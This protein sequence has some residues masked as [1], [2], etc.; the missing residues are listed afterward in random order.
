MD[1]LLPL[2]KS[3]NRSEV[4]TLKNLLAINSSGVE[5]DKRADLFERIQ[6]SRNHDEQVVARLL[7]YSGSSEKAYI[8]LKSRLRDDILNLLML[9]ED[10]RAFETAFAQAAFECRRW[11]IQGE[12]LLA[13]GVYDGAID[14]LEKA[15]HQAH[16]YEL[17]AEFILIADLLRNHSAVKGDLDTFKGINE[18]I[19]EGQGDLN[20]V[21]KAKQ[22][23]YEI[24]VPGL[25]HVN[26]QRGYKVQAGELLSKLEN[27][28]RRTSSSR[29]AFYQHLAALN[30]YSAL[31]EFPE[32]LRHGRKLL[33]QVSE[34]QLLKSDANQAGVNMEMAGICLNTGD[35]ACAVRHAETAVGLFK[36]GMVN[37]MQALMIL[38]FAYFRSGN[39]SEATR[40]LDLAQSHKQALVDPLLEH[41][42]HL[43]RSG[44]LFSQ[45]DYTQSGKLLKRCDGLLKAHDTWLP[46]WFLLDTLNDFEQQ[47][48]DRAATKLEAF[49]KQAARL[50]I[51]EGARHTR[52]RSILHLMHAFVRAKDTNH[53][54][55]KEKTEITQLREATGDYHWNPAGYELIRFDEWLMKKVG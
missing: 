11:L 24:T 6:K 34:D 30:Y 54:L 18:L 51:N 38:F 27:K 12:L 47:R 14:V 52:L 44:L 23:Y 55:L 41:R 42:I 35:Y 32:A 20:S 9:Q 13:R 48:I 53:L 36:P 43:L 25:L 3:L 2:I 8:N 50:G 16:K 15:L 26:T 29:I 17:H 31:R 49:R 1:S 22:S 10:G 4:R 46:G 28:G 21:L 39:I 7:G 19:A 33:K 37:H 45:G 5:N 40:T